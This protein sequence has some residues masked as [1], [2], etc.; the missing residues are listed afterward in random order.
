[1][2]NSQTKGVEIIFPPDNYRITEDENI[3]VISNEPGEWS[4]D[5]QGIVG[6]GSKSSFNPVH[7]IQKLTV[8]TESQTSDSVTI[9]KTP[10]INKDGYV[11]GSNI[12]NILGGY[13]IDEYGYKK[14]FTISYS[15]YGTN[16]LSTDSLFLDTITLRLGNLFFNS[17]SYIK[18]THSIQLGEDNIYTWIG[19]DIPFVNLIDKSVVII[20]FFFVLQSSDNKPSS[21][22]KFLLSK[23]AEQNDGG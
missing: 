10:Y 11:I 4:T 8:T 17:Y 20:S 18:L 15:Q 7:G 13:F 1:M 16:H 14:E 21:I 2:G 6:Y 3:T 22:Q 19:T 23:T 12:Y 9:K 5:K